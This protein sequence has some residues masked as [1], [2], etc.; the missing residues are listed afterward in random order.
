[1]TGKTHRRG[2]NLF[3]LMGFWY[4]FRNGLAHPTIHP[5]LQVLIMYPFAIWGS[6]ASDFD[7]VWSSC[8]S[9]DISGYIVHRVLFLFNPLKD[10][11][12]RLG[13]KNTRLYKV[14]KILSAEHRSW[15]THS[16]LTLVVL[17][18]LLYTFLKG[19][20]WSSYLSRYD[21]ALISV[22]LTGVLMGM[23][24]HIVLDMMT[25]DGV[26][27]IWGVVLNKIMKKDI[28]P[29]KYRLVPKSKMFSVSTGWEPFMGKVVSILTVLFVLFMIHEILFPNLLW[30][31]I[32]S[33]PYKVSFT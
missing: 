19:D 27:C 17:S 11:L 15:Q 5:A 16:D 29:T 25:M 31:M 14:V 18:V 9:K 7:H 30:G 21:I 20:I 3:A 13:Q 8:P 23:I 32:T 4:L 33:F 24:S 10:R 28:A 12:E 26:W 1:M 6:Y 2:G 22:I